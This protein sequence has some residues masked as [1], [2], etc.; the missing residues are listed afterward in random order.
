MLAPGLVT[1]G[2]VLDVLSEG[3]GAKGG[4]QSSLISSSFCN[5]ARCERCRRRARPLLACRTR[6]RAKCAPS[7]ICKIVA[8]E[9]EASEI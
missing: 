7:I 8:Q 1:L 5:L 9:F 6:R 2:S 3:A 4:T